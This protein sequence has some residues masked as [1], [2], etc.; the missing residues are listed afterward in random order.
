M[1]MSREKIIEDAKMLITTNRENQ[2]KP[3]EDSF[4]VISDLW[5]AYL[6]SRFGFEGDVTSGDVAVMMALMKIGRISG[7]IYKADSYIDAVG[8]I[9]IAG[10]ISDREEE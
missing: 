6:K 4:K 7:G 8:Y 2:Y 9:A 3:A 10:E 5:G 1:R